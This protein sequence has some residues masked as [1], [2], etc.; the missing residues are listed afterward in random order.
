[1][2]KHIHNAKIQK[3]IKLKKSPVLFYWAVLTL[4]WSAGYGYRKSGCS[5]CSSKPRFLHKG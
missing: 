3:S 5:S 4:P 2:F 1:M